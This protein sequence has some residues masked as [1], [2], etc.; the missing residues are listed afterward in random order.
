VRRWILL[1]S[2]LNSNDLKTK[3]APYIP[4]LNGRVLRRRG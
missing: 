1:N 2:T 3:T 4:A